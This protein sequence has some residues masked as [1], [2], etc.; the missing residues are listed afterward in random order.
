MLLGSGES[1]ATQSKQTH[2]GV[3]L[4]VARIA[5]KRFFPIWISLTRRIVEL[6]N[7]LAGQ[8]KLF[9]VSDGFRRRWRRDNFGLRHRLQTH[10]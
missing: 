9:I 8:E 10:G 2:A 5:T 3:R 4:D 7:A 1:R 6:I